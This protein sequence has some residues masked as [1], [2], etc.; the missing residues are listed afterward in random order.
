MCPTQYG[1]G[2]LFNKCYALI[3]VFRI[4]D[5]FYTDSDPRIHPTGLWIRILLFSSEALKKIVK[6]TADI[7]VFLNFYFASGSGSV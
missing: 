7:M 3:A 2:Y 5:V 1:T 6:K 4:R